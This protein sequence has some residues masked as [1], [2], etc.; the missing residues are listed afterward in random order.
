[1]IKLLKKLKMM[2][3]YTYL[4]KDIKE[5]SLGKKRSIFNN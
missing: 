3:L 1:M 5:V 2:D 4:G